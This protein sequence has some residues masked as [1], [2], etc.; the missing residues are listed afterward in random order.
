MGKLELGRSSDK[1]KAQF[2][3][4]IQKIQDF[5]FGIEFDGNG[6]QADNQSGFDPTMKPERKV[7][8]TFF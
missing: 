1:V 3:K 6:I 2:G 8:I 4:L 7:D 5:L